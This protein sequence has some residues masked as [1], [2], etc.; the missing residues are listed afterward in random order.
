MTTTHWL[1]RLLF[2]LL[3]EPRGAFEPRVSS[4]SYRRQLSLPSPSLKPG[5]AIRLH[6]PLQLRRRVSYTKLHPPTCHLGSP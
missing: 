6:L 5:C 3:Q 1:V 4:P 2:V